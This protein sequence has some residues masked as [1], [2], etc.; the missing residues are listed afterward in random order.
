VALEVA[1]IKVAPGDLPSLPIDAV[2]SKGEGRHV[3]GLIGGAFFDHFVVEID[4]DQSRL[5][6]HSPT[7]FAP[8]A[9]VQAIPISVEEGHC[10]LDAVLVL[11]GG[12]KMNGRFMID[13][14][15][16]NAI[17]VAGP[18][19]AA[20]Q[21][22]A[23]LRG[24]VAVTTGVGLGGESRS[25]AGRA[26]ALE[27]GPLKIERPI[28]NVSTDRKGALSAPGHAGILG[29]ELLRRYRAIFDY[30]QRR[31]YLI[32]GKPAAE[33]YDL[34]MSGLFVTAHGADLK[35]FEVLSVVAD[36]PAARAGIAPGDIITSVD[37][38][39]ASQLTLEEIRRAF[40]KGEGTEYS[41]GLKRGDTERKVRLR[42]RRLI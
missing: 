16:R 22:P 20:H 39:S 8:P 1:G 12:R 3:D 25:T 31:L 13:T 38:R 37:D 34:D 40:L 15:L 36:S 14:G 30:P 32:P 10:Y 18:F 28:V 9:R 35:R 4:Y 2:V 24:N 17:A 7:T 33:P 21:V 23:G 5:T 11:S 6:F 41:L 19:G 29:G 27:L 26:E 42:L